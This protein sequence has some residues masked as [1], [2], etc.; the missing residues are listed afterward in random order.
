LIFL[1][2]SNI[3]ICKCLMALDVI[4][5]VFPLLANIALTGAYD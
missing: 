2:S 3:Q 1:T 5:D 4:H